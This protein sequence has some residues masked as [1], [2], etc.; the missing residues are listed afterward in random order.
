M[1]VMQFFSRV[2]PPGS[3]VPVEHVHPPNT[4]PHRRAPRA[5]SCEALLAPPARK[6]SGF[7]PSPPPCARYGAHGWLA[8]RAQPRLDASDG[9]RPLHPAR[10]ASGKLWS[11]CSGAPRP[12][13]ILLKADS[14]RLWVRATMTE[15]D[16][17]SRSILLPSW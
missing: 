8:R 9:A 3:R 5:A 4:A 2:E 15:T 10:V 11:P 13:L 6:S 1:P 17:W 16:A 12:K 14:G 7:G